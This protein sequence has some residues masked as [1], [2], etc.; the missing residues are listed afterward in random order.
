MK[1]ILIVDDVLLMRKMLGKIFTDEGYIVCGEA[2]N[3][4]E[5]VQKYRELKPDLVTVDIVMPRVGDLDGLG[6]IREMVKLDP[7]AKVI[8]VSAMGQHALIAEGLEAG[9]KYFLIKPVQPAQL[10]QTAKN[11]LEPE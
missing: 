1:K 7:Q 6:A 10:L 3:G 2:E 5:A 11:V 9:A 4:L 8:I